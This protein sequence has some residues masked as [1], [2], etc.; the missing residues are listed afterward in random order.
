MKL[1][2]T[3]IDDRLKP[4]FWPGLTDEVKQYSK[5]W[6]ED[7]SSIRDPAD[8][9]TY[10]SKSRILPE[11]AADFVKTILSSDDISNRTRIFVIAENDWGEKTG[12]VSFFVELSA[13]N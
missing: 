10:T 4:F 9:F 1:P 13:Y 8:K 3:Y 6:R 11:K 7:L 2:L 12:N 5:R